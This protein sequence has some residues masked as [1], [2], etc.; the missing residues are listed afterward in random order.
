MSR[1]GESAVSWSA[2]ESMPSVECRRR[3]LKKT[4]MYSKTSV[5]SSAFE[6]QVRPW[7]SSFLSV[8]KKLS[9]TALSKQSPRL[10]ID[11]AM[12]A[13]RA[14]WPKASETNRAALIGVPD[15][16]RC[17]PALRERHLQRVA[18]QLGAHVIGPCSSRRFAG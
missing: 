12:P 16:P 18:D 11:W 14:C 1:M 7:M 3:R 10:P 15:Q 8:A 13:A 5:R 4:S 2:G 6:G 9:A 17:G